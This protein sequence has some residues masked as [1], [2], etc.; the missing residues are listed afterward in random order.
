M[1]GC[2]PCGLAVARRACRRRPLR[3]S[4]GRGWLALHGAWP[5]LA[6]PPRCLRCETQQKWRSYI[7]V[8]QIRMEKM[9]E[10]KRPLL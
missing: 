6:A 8:F 5:W 9:N 10:V 1:G 7:T 2:R 4:L 3:A